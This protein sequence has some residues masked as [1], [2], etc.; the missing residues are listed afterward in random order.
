MPVDRETIL[1]M[2]TRA[3][4]NNV[5]VLRLRTRGAPENFFTEIADELKT[6]TVGYP[7]NAAI[8]NAITTLKRM[9]STTYNSSSRLGRALLK[10]CRS[11]F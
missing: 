8:D 11:N 4:I 2:I 5:N 10:M 3:P 1:K 9:A 6:S 7:G